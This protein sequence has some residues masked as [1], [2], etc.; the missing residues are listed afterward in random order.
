MSKTT[1]TAST[2]ARPAS[3]AWSPTP[4]FRASVL[5]TAA[6]AATADRSTAVPR[7]AWMTDYD[8]DDEGRTS[9]EFIGTMSSF[10]HEAV[11]VYEVLEGRAGSPWTFTMTG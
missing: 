11:T 6:N 8:E 1:S 10:G 9:F 5:G 7:S 2:S 3:S 4:R